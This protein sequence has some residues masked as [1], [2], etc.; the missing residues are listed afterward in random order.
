VAKKDHPPNYVV[1][2][3]FEKALDWAVDLH[4]DQGRK[5]SRTPYVG[6]LLGVA[7][8]VFEDGGSEDEAIAALLHDAIEDRDRSGL[9]QALIAAFGKHVVAIV[10][11]CSQEGGD[12]DWRTRKQ[13]YIDHLADPETQPEVLRVSLADKLHNVRSILRDHRELSHRLWKRFNADP[14]ETLW[15]YRRLREIYLD[16]FPGAM[17][18]EFAAEVE[19][20]ESIIA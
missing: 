6:H 8:Y 4:R 17:A 20:L 18:E 2:E 19:R 1:S 14:A 12:A 13:R 3:R 9:T 16:R 10:Q 15:Y 11:G 5:G 7:G